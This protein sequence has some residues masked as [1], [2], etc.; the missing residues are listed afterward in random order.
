[1]LGHRFVLSINDTPEIRTLFA[2]FTN[3]EVGVNYRLSGKVTA[4]RKLIISGR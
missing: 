3:E 1:M 2:G 4:A